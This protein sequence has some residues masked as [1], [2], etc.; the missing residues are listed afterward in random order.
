MRAEADE[1]LAG[2]ESRA[3]PACSVSLWDTLR[4]RCELPCSDDA[5]KG[6]PASSLDE[7]SLSCK[8]ACMQRL[9]SIVLFTKNGYAE[10][11]VDWYARVYLSAWLT[12]MHVCI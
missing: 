11:L 3:R 9:G 7:C 1:G 6:L 12:G 10:C 2:S 4:T 8:V 5:D